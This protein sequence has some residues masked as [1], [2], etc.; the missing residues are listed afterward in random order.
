MENNKLDEPY[1]IDELGNQIYG[2]TYSQYSAIYNEL[3]SDFG[4]SQQQIVESASFSL[5]MVIRAALAYSAAEA[6]SVGLISDNLPSCVVLAALR[7]LVNAGTDT[8]ILYVKDNNHN[9]PEISSYLH[10]LKQ[11]RIKILEINSINDLPDL[12]IYLKDAHNVVCGL[13]SIN[14]GVTDLEKQIIES[15]NSIKTPIHCVEAPIGLNVDDGSHETPT[16]YASSTLSLG[17]PLKGLILGNVYCGRNYICDISFTKKSYEIV[18]E[19]LGKIF[20][21]Q[22]VIRLFSP[23]PEPEKE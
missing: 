5:A 10:T 13:S 8:S 17:L 20:S 9:F 16:L 11:M 6:Y 19:E 21:S 2:I 12:G 15:L 1:L 22:P 18:N 7:H 3:I 14:K 4:I 23:R